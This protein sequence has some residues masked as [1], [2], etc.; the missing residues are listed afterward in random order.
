MKTPKLFTLVELLVVVAVI[1]ILASLLLPVLGQARERS[2]ET[3]CV[4]NLKQQGFAMFMYHSDHDDTFVEWDGVSSGAHGYHGWR[5]P[6]AQYL[7]DRSGFNP[8][9]L[10]LS[11]SFYC[12]NYQK[13][14][15]TLTGHA[16]N[17]YE[18]G[19]HPH[20]AG[21]ISRMTPAKSTELDRVPLFL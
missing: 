8:N 16:Y 18:L 7:Q 6:L 17:M 5:W 1:S 4:S 2:Q 3:L 12:P 15:N 10:S 20:Q 9:T 11:K 21:V 19:G 14:N 13:P